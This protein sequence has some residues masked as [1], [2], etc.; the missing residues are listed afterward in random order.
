MSRTG[1]TVLYTVYIL[2]L[3]LYRSE[4]PFVIIII[5]QL[6][7]VCCAWLVK[8]SVKV[9]GQAGPGPVKL[10]LGLAPLTLGFAPLLCLPWL[11]IRPVEREALYFHQRE[12]VL[13]RCAAW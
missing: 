1:G 2:L 6:V 8:W 12:C 5:I 10:T 4:W 11:A 3:L 13:L 9:E 7:G